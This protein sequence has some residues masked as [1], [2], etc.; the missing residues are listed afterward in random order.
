[1]KKVANYL[2]VFLLL[3]VLTSC[4]KEEKLPDLPL[5]ESYLPLELGKSILYQVDSLTYI[6]QTAL[7][8]SVRWYERETI[9]SLYTT[10]D[11]KQA[12]SVKFYR[13][14][15]T[16][17]M[18][19]EHV[20]LL[21][22][23]QNNVEERSLGLNTVVISFPVRENVSWKGNLNYTL[24]YPLNF[25]FRNLHLPIVL[26]TINLD[27]TLIVEQYKELN[28]I[29]DIHFYDVYANHIGKVYSERKDIETQPGDKTGT[30]IRKTLINYQR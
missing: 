5:Y 30:L 7:P 27:S 14:N 12:Y 25:R 13:G 2:A 17:N 10:L 16:L 1:M 26:E 18:N 11:G 21:I 23:N 28:F 15:D 22:P 29:Q 8:D 9:D 3:A 19:L 24:N 20:Y 6:S 4:E